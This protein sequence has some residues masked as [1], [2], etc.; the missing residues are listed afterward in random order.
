[1]TLPVTGPF[2]DG[3][4]AELYDQYRRDPAS[5]EEPWRQYFRFAEQLSGAAGSDS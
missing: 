2:N 1:M 4:I 3:F 5:V